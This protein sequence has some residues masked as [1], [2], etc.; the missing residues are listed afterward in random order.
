MNKEYKVYG[1]YTYE[2]RRGEIILIK[3]HSFTLNKISPKVLVFLA[4]T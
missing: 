2:V 3:S 4:K 1:I